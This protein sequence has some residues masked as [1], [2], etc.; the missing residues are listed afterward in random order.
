[1]TKD[2]LCNIAGAIVTVLLFALPMPGRDHSALNGTWELVPARSNFAGEP[3]VQT[4]IVTIKSEDR[5]IVVERNFKYSGARETYFYSDITDANGGATIHTGKD[6]M[7]KT[8]WDHDVLSVTTT[9]N[10]AVTVERYNLAADGSMM[11]NVAR[12]GRKSVELAFRRK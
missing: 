2:S 11:V 6:L 10:G 9:H 12:P 7:S 5:V 4:G 8:K 1:M 3:T